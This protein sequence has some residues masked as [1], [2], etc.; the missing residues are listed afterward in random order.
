MQTDDANGDTVQVGLTWDVVATAT[1]KDTLHAF[2]EVAWILNGDIIC[3]V[4]VFSTFHFL[5]A[6]NY[7]KLI[8]FVL[9]FLIVGKPELFGSLMFERKKAS[10]MH[11]IH[12][13]QFL[14]IW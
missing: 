10:L 1:G 12:I 5:I 13:K 7:L 9:N 11:C 14:L 4:G 3:L 6:G 8:L 2:G